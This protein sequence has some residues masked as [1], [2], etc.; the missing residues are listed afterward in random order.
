M[1][2]HASVSGIQSDGSGYRS[3]RLRSGNRWARRRGNCQWR[4]CKLF[5]ASVLEPI[6]LK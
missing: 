5:S 1:W 4:A 3:A 6:N 2:A